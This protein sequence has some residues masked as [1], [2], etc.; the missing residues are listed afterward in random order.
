MLFHSILF[1]SKRRTCINPHLDYAFY[2]GFDQQNKGHAYKDFNIFYLRRHQ[3]NSFFQAARALEPYSR[4]FDGERKS[5]PNLQ[6][7]AR[8]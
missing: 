4:L 5:P 2:N 7:S 8:F 1:F 6:N 3:Q